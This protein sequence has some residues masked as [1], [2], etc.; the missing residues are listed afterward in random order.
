[1]AFRCG[2]P[3][4]LVAL[5]AA[6][7]ASEPPRATAL[8]LAG[9][10]WVV[11]DIDGRGIV[12]RVESTLTIDAAG[13]AAGAGGCNRYFG[14]VTFAAG[15]IS[16]GT[17]GSTRMACPTAVM[18]QEQRFFAALEATRS[19]RQDNLT[20]LLYFQ[21]STGRDILRLRQMRKIEATDDE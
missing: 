9:T 11:E 10:Q 20:G 14:D 13:R 1:M 15:E 21:D 7:C 5:V 2:I 3:V 17:L 12:D 19:Y 16:F 18:D 8:D 4:A 6:A